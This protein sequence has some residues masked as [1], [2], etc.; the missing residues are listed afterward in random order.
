MRTA[1]RPPGAR[2]PGGSPH[3]RPEKLFGFFDAT[4]AVELED[5]PWLRSVSKATREVW[6][7]PGAILSTFFDASDPADLRISLMVTEDVSEDLGA[8]FMKS[9]AL[10]TRDLGVRLYRRATAGSLRNLAPEFIPALAQTTP[11]GMADSFGVIGSNPDGVG[12][13]VTVGAGAPIEVSD[14]EWSVYKCMAA[15]LSAAFRLRR[16]LRAGAAPEPTSVSNGAEA[17][18]DPAGRVLHAEGLADRPGALANLKQAIRSFDRARTRGRRK[19]PL[20]GIAEHRP[21]VD[22]RW[23]LVDAYQRG[24][25]RYIVARENLAPVRGLARLTARERQVAAL[26]ALGRSTK[27]IAYAL[28]IADSTARVLLARAAVRLGARTREELIRATTREALPEL[29][30]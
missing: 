28:G 16:R 13:S 5:E 22:A 24:G 7:E 3:L 11:H 12:C 18:L 26:L 14:A 23:T 10:H 1:S 9:F 2:R 25:A 8:V 6:G 15:H 19:D 21:L 4:Y 27:E 20:A 29:E 17:V 30:V